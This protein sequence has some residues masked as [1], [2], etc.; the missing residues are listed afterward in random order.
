VYVMHPCLIH[1]SHASESY[2]SRMF[3]ALFIDMSLLFVYPFSYLFLYYLVFTVSL[4]FLFGY[5]IYI[6]FKSINVF[7][8]LSIHLQYI[9]VTCVLLIFRIYTYSHLIVLPHIQY[10]QSYISQVVICTNMVRLG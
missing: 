2:M 8:Y 4:L 1:G 7:V 3:F 5:I 10:L 6:L 9:H